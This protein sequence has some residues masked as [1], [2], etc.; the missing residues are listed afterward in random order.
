LKLGERIEL[1]RK[2]VSG[3]MLT[4]LLIGMLTSAF[5]VQQARAESDGPRYFNENPECETDS[6]FYRM[7]STVSSFT[8]GWVSSQTDGQ[9]VTGYGVTFFSNTASEYQ[10]ASFFIEGQDSEGMTEWIP[11][12]TSRMTVAFYVKYMV[13]SWDNI[14]PQNLPKFTI[15][16]G[17]TLQVLAEQNVTQVAN[18]WFTVMIYTTIE[19][20]KSF[21]ALWEFDWTNMPPSKPVIYIDSWRVVTFDSEETF[22]QAPSDQYRMDKFGPASSNFPYGGSSGTLSGNLVSVEVY[23]VMGVGVPGLSLWYE[24]TKTLITRIPTYV[25]SSVWDSF[26]QSTPW[27]YYWSFRV[28][29]AS[30]DI[31][32]TASDIE[33]SDPYYTMWPIGS[34][35]WHQAYSF[36]LIHYVDTERVVASWIDKGG[37]DMQPYYSPDYGSLCFESGSVPAP[38]IT[39]PSLGIYQKEIPLAGFNVS[40]SRFCLSDWGPWSASSGWLPISGPTQTI[41]CVHVSA[42]PASICETAGQSSNIVATVSDQL[43]NPLPGVNVAFTSSQGTLSSSS[44]LT[45]NLGEANVTLSPDNSTISLVVATVSAVANGVSAS[46]NVTFYPPSSPATS[47]KTCTQFD[48]RSSS[49]NFSQY[50]GPFVYAYNLINWFNS[51]KQ[52]SIDSLN[53]LPP[54]NVYT[55][56]PSS[57]ADQSEFSQALSQF[58]GIT[59]PENYNPESVLIVELPF[60]QTINTLFGTDVQGP[61]SFPIPSAGG[62]EVFL[63][64]NNVTTTATGNFILAFTF[65]K[66]ANNSQ[67]VVDILQAMANRLV[68]LVKESG[69][70]LI[71]NGVDILKG[72]IEVTGDISIS[73]VTSDLDQTGLLNSYTL[74]DLVHIADTFSTIASVGGMA[75]KVIDLLLEGTEA[76]GSTGLNLWADVK[77]GIKAADLG[78]EILPYLPDLSF[79]KDNS[80]YQFYANG[81]SM[82]ADIM[83]PNGTTIVPSY[84]D[85]AGSLVLGYNSSSGNIIYASTEGILIPEAGDWLALLNE[86][87]SN[88]VDYTICLTTVGGNASV[89][90]NIQIM[91]PNQ[92]VTTI[93]YSGMVLGGTSTTIPVNVAVNDTLIRQ[94]YL[95]PMISV[96][97]T[98]NVFDFVATGMLSNGSLASVTNAFLIINGSQ[99]EMTQDNSSTFETQIGLSFPG[100]VQFFIYMISPDV[101]GGFATGFLQHEVTVSNVTLAKTKVG[102]GYTIRINATLQNQGDYDETFNVTVYA[103][104][105]T[106]ETQTI[107]LTSGN[108]TTI[109]FTWNTTGFA[110]GNC[111][112]S[113]YAWPLPGETNTANNNCTGSN[114]IVTIPGD[115]NGDFNVS[116][117]DLVILAQAYGSKPT[118][119]NWNPNADIDGNSI[120]G[121]SDLVIMA[122]YYGQHYP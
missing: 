15:A 82:I 107:T 72:I 63:N 70:D 32:Y 21:R 91:S 10:N 113:A 25:G 112:T 104:T 52:I 87:A 40:G 111:T 86:N 38:N 16:D 51:S 57:S 2:T 61:M 115:L 12:S 41:S 36:G 96:S 78:L 4:L 85:S 102:Q 56:T 95:K 64:A 44:V 55:I 100:P 116:L 48:I 8:K 76:V 6:S 5:S 69:A 98:R 17:Q 34:G 75:K 14:D 103:N 68:S 117:A 58:L 20:G 33:M 54:G 109:I 7:S 97:E 122:K 90:Y 83:D 39:S 74:L 73:M 81:V 31:I 93:G 37:F 47:W 105:T 24:G 89:P 42:Y 62:L 94:V 11:S 77:T 49:M 27:F 110:Y 79:L 29:L 71:Q 66:V 119:S 120:V 22:T 121:L 92:N 59:A 35:Q 23:D 108:S 43:G 118:D 50:L 13:N 1:L 19:Q 60:L 65:S 26:Y 99:Y 84:Y 28:I 46:T 45:D 106:I 30:K 18:Q 80:L 53:N 9:G 3:I 67:G 101:P 88:P 114:V